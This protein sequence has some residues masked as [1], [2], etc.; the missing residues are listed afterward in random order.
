[1]NTKYATLMRDFGPGHAGAEVKRRCLKM[2]LISTAYHGRVALTVLKF[3]VC[4]LIVGTVVA[5]LFL[6]PPDGNA[7][8]PIEGASNVEYVGRA[9]WINP[10]TGKEEIDPGAYSKLSPWPL[11]DGRYL[12]SGCDDPAPLSA[13][14]PGADRCF[15][16]VDLKDPVKP[17]RLATV[18]TFDP[19][20]SPPPPRGHVVWSATYP[21]PN[22][23]VQVP[24]KVDWNDPG[25]KA[26]TSKPA[27]WDPGW[28]THTHYLQKGAGK[29]LAVNQERYRGGTDRQASFHGVKFYDIANPAKP[30]FLSYW[31][32]PVS[33]PD[34]ST[35]KWP[36][37]DGVHHFNF[38]G[39]YLYLGGEYK[40]YIGKILVILDTSDPRHPKEVG[41]WWVKGQREDEYPSAGWVMQQNTSS[42]IQMVNGKLS[43]AMQMHYVTI[44]GDR[45]YLAYNQGGL[46]ILDVKDKASP[47]LVSLLDYLVPGYPSPD[48]AQCGEG[49]ACGN[50]HSAKLIPGRNLLMVSDEYFRCPYGHV[51]IVD[52]SDEKNPK[53]ISN[54]LTDQNLACNGT[55]STDPARFP[56]RGPTSHLGNALDSNLYFMAWYGMGLRVIDTSDPYHPKEAGYYLYQWDKSEPKSA[57]DAYDVVFGPKGYLYV[58][59]GTNGLRVVKFTGKNPSP[60]ASKK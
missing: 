23:P 7:V 49:K 3:F 37:A 29:F 19:V 22:L 54:F 41:K 27:C 51:R 11:T 21:F 33:D 46:V 58:A 8:G 9:V 28:N 16:T 17:M 6:F 1:M 5:A 39:R 56:R 43:K 15:M 26:G 53:I 30:V 31:E 55:A 57:C 4:V 47:K 13:T 34:P 60:K 12:Y 14:I 52:I 42:P 36:D 48:S 10:L 18:Y 50:T 25:I 38:G 45:A 40:G 20:A 59:D 32:T 44:K 35:G 2:G 24:C